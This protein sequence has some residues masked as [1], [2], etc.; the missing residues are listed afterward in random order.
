[1]ISL[2]K[3]IRVATDAKHGAFS[4]ATAAIR[5]VGLNINAF[6]AYQQGNKAYFI[7]LTEDNERAMESLNKAG[8]ETTEEEA[9]LTSLTHRVGTL[10]MAAHKL[11]EAGIDIRY[12]YATVAGSDCLAVFSTS[13]N[14]KAL[15]V[16]RS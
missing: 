5:G 8:F 11:L 9:V 12:C 16:L 3:E 2:I 4:K 6:C 7:F 10:D 1:M 13:D 14:K 15:Q